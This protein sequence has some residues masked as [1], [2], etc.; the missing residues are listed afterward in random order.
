MKVKKVL[1]LTDN[2][3]QVQ[4][5]ASAAVELGEEVVLVYG[6]EKDAAVGAARAYWLG[7]FK[8]ST[9]INSVSDVVAIVAKEQP[10]LVLVC[11]STNGRL[12][13][14]YISVAND[15]AVMSDASSVEV[16]R[17]V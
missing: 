14:G 5:L 2:D 10:D 11:N 1:A 15:V 9:F 8:N 3:S 13:A 16:T 7:D 6:G 4:E 17:C 12:A